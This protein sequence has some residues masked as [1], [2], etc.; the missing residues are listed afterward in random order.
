MIDLVA[1][2]RTW[3]GHVGVL[4]AIA[5]LHPAITLR[6]ASARGAA[7]GSGAAVGARLRAG[8]RWSVALATA[9]VT[10]TTFAGW[11][12]YPG[13]RATEKPRLLQEAFPVALLF[14][15]KE[16]L[17]FYA[18][19]LAWAGCALVFGPAGAASRRIARLCFG[20]SAGLVIVVGVLGTV[21]GSADLG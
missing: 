15:T 19:V 12:L 4:A 20:A 11:W 18:L 7:G 16:H 8:T 5:L 3:H 17:A 1:L 6:P 2:A 21:V 13:Y 14:E 9:L 10:L